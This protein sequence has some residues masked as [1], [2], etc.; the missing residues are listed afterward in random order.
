[1]Q[2]GQG[3][4]L[5]GLLSIEIEHSQYSNGDFRIAGT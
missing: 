1:M 3:Q 4:Q 5:L 2:L